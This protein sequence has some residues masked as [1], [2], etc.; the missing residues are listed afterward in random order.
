MT[1]KSPDWFIGTCRKIF[2]SVVIF[3]DI[4]IGRGKFKMKRINMLS[5][6]KGRNHNIYMCK[7]I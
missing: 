5:Y 7:K 4:F 2:L 3:T 1:Y 6:K